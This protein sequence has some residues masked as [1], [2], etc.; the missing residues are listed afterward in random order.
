MCD[1]CN[2]SGCIL[3]TCDKCWGNS[4][5]D[6]HDSIYAWHCDKCHGDGYVKIECSVC[7]GECI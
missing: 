3:T 5:K 4:D 2:N 6:T 7:K 1:Y